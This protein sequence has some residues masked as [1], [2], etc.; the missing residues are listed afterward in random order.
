M[1]M[2]RATKGFSVPG[3]SFA[4]GEEFDSADE[5]RLD[6]EQVLVLERMKRIERFTPEEKPAKK[7]AKLPG[8]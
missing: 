7:P 4:S 6:R 2:Y 5:K 8:T 3:R 1:T